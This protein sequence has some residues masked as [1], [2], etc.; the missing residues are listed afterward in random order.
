[1]ETEPDL[2][3]ELVSDT[4]PQYLTNPKP[5]LLETLKLENRRLND[6]VAILKKEKCIMSVASAKDQALTDRTNKFNKTDYFT[7]FESTKR[8]KSKTRRQQ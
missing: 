1:M 7:M 8:T 3:I 6:Q 2:K 4:D 5:E